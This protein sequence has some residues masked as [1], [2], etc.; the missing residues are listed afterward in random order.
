M[1]RNY[2]RV[3]QLLNIKEFDYTGSVKFR[4]LMEHKERNREL[5]IIY[6]ERKNKL[7]QLA[8]RLTKCNDALELC[9]EEETTADVY[10]EIEET[11]NPDRTIELNRQLK[12]I[13]EASLKLKICFENLAMQL[14]LKDTSKKEPT[15]LEVNNRLQ[16]LREQSQELYQHFVDNRLPDSAKNV[17]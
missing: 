2:Q 11:D 5:N 12:N 3:A 9:Y 7:E 13:K 1:Q 15:L 8:A 10:P 14:K 6:F 17:A 4:Q 16:R